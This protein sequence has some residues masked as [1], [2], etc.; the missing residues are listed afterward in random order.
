MKNQHIFATPNKLALAIALTISATS[1]IVTAQEQE[2]A[3]ES[4]IETIM[5]T[6]SKRVSNAQETSIAMDVMGASDLLE[7]GVNDIAQLQSIAPG[8]QIGTSATATIV[9]VRGVSGRDTTEIGDPAVAINVDGIFLQRPSGMNASFF[10]LDRIEV[11]RGP[12]GTLYGR[13]ATGGVINIISKRPD[14]D[15]GGYASV[16]M[17]NYSTLNGEGAFNLPLSD[18]LAMRASFSSKNHEGFR[19]NSRSAI[20][21][22]PELNIPGVG[23][24][25][26]RVTVRGDDEESQGARL[27]ILYDDGDKLSVLLS[28][29]QIYQGGNGPVIAGYPTDRETP[30]T[31]SS[32]AKRFALSEPGDFKLDR[33]TLMAQVEYDFGFATAT[34]LFGSAGLDVDHLYDNDGTEIGVGYDFRRSE[35][36]TDMSHE[37]RLSSNE[38]SPLSWQI[39]AFFYDQD[40]DVRS[41][42][43]ISPEGTDPVF[44]R[45]YLFNVQVESKAAFGQIGYEIT[46]QISITTGL[47]YSEDSKVRTGTFVGGPSLGNPPL[48]QPDLVVVP[49]GDGSRSN[50]DDL[51]YH[52]G[53]DYKYTKN[54]ML[55]AKVDKGYK[56]GGFTSINEYGP[57][58]VQAFEVGSK[59]RLLD[60]TLQL[61][62][63]AFT[64]QYEDQQVSQLTEN[65]VQVQ[66]A[67]SSTVNGIE[68]ETNWMLTQDD[69]IELS[70]NWLDAQYD[71]FKVR[72][73]DENLDQAG[74]QLIQAPEWAISGSYEHF[75]EL[76]NGALVIPKIQF[77][78]RSESYFTFFNNANDRQEAYTTLDFSLSYK[79][80]GQDWSIQAYGRNLTDEVILTSASTAS[81]TGTN[82]YQFAAPRTYGVRFTTH[83]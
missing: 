44:L 83:F 56:S 46:D 31:D 81:F 16:T 41:L 15:L 68:V 11:L 70:V 62:I 17:G 82:G 4:G 52:L 6:A 76:S 73:G 66:N 53:V 48:T 42:N 67:G 60:N 72:V 35:Y 40:L 78:H 69:N 57:E 33:Q 32:E 2:E 3:Q 10:D 43:F 64:Y 7:N 1:T 24:P 28:A 55:Y 14:F 80:V 13:N 54:S 75:F 74:N 47:R 9:T 63:T 50:D 59:N 58:T 61:N 21:D 37:I 23:G 27:Q 65:G 49:L 25:Q 8:V 34:Y 45:N 26:N 12:Q 38:T 39:G 20:T 77:L 18:N 19:D 71:D 30:P 51:S 36:S 22:I 79:P 5:V 29:T